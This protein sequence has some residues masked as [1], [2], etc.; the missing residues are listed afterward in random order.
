MVESFGMSEFIHMVPVN[1][2]MDFDFEE[3]SWYNFIVKR[4]RRIMW[5]GPCTQ[6]HFLNAISRFG[7]V[8]VGFANEENS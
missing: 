8:F 4:K 2:P 6:H 7:A 5:I 1:D 3:N